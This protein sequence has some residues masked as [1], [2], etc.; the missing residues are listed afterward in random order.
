ML[1]I[2]D[3]DGDVPEDVA[4]K[5]G[6]RLAWIKN[7]GSSE[8]KKTIYI[9]ADDYDEDDD[10]EDVSMPVTSDMAPDR[11]KLLPASFFTSMRNISPFNRELLKRAIRTKN[12]EL[13]KSAQPPK[14]EIYLKDHFDRAAADLKAIEAKHFV[15][16]RPP[17]AISTFKEKTD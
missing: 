5:R 15:L 7:K 6:V 11:D 4:R 9:K 2:Y 16:Y 8:P 14:Q 13:L 10:P 17:N 12:E 1:R 3:G